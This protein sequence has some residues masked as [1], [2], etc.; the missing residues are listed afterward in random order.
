MLVKL[1]QEQKDL[2]RLITPEFRLSHPH[3]FT[4]QS[5]KP[6]DKKKFSG[7]MLF[8]KGVKLIGLAPDRKTPRTIQE[9]ITSA[10]VITFGTKD[11]WP[12][13]LLSPVNDGD[14][15]KYAKKEG[16]K[17]HWVIKATSSE[18]QRP[19]IVGPDGKELKEASQIYPGC[20]AR[21]FVFAYVWEYMGKQGVGFILDHVQKLRDGP[22]F[23]GK[24]PIDQVFGPIGTESE[25]EAEDVDFR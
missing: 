9:V 1:T 6:A 8:E 15:V 20:Y 3:L 12:A 14:A 22:S 11:K 19:G 4:P 5:P 10:K 7:T 16:Y 23:G 13:E 25:E 2:C 21:A 17:G 18:D 24:R